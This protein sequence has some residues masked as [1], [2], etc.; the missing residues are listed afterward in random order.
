[1]NCNRVLTYNKI[2]EN[3]N[4]YTKV[5]TNLSQ[6]IKNSKTIYNKV[7]TSYNFFKWVA[8]K[9]QQIVKKFPWIAIGLWWLAKKFTSMN[10]KKKIPYKLNKL[11]TSCNPMSSNEWQQSL[12]WWET[13]DFQWVVT[14]LILTYNKTTLCNKKNWGR[15]HTHICKQTTLGYI[16]TMPCLI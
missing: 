9:F 16:Y 11:I 7:P 10:Y 13:I 12:L 3:F 8:T 4:C 1:M 6:V 5:F 2:I 15:N 14:K